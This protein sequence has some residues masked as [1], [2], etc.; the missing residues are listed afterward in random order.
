MTYSLGHDPEDY[1]RFG[2]PSNAPFSRSAAREICRIAADQ[3][4]QL[5]GMDGG[6]YREGTFQ[7]DIQCTSTRNLTASTYEAAERINL[8]LIESIDEDPPEINA[9]MITSAPFGRDVE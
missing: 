4:Y 2:C 3:G 6:T 5:L 7:P 1:F 8:S 9:Y